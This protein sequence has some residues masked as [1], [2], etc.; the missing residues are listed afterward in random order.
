M[1]DR[2]KNNTLCTVAAAR[3]IRGA[4]GEGAWSL[5]A[6]PERDM[7]REQQRQQQC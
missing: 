4:V 1:L 7:L 3:A 2:D 5:G 6:R